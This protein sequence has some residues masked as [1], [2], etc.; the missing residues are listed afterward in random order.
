MSFPRLPRTASGEV[1]LICTHYEDGRALWGELPK[2]TGGAREGDVLVLD[3]GSGRDGGVRLRVAEDP[4]WDRVYGGNVPALV[5]D[6]GPLPPVAVLADVSVAYG[7]RGPLLVDLAVTPGRGVRVP[8]DRLGEILSA[9]LD[10]SLTF[11]ALV[12][13]MDRVGLYQ[14]DDGRPLL[15]V[16][17]AP[18]R[19]SFPAL[20]ATGAALLVRTSFDDEDGWR[21]LLDGLGGVDEDGMIGADIDHEEIDADRCPLTALVVD[22]RAFEALRHDQVSALVPPGEETVL[23]ALA[24]ADTFAGEER[25]LIAVDLYDTPGQPAVLPCHEV[26]S[27]AANLEIANMDFSDFVP[28]D[29]E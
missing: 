22:D 1:L 27:L 2:E 11:D 23:V 14:G 10:F 24:D 25:P 6:D 9:V 15:P 29:G 18:R 17:T 19:T 16:P 12:R 8:A 4:A 26:G 3:G 7:G 28:V 20:P 5:A 13:D 21:A